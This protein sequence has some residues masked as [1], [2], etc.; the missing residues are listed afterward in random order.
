MKKLICLPAIFL[1]GCATIINSE[2]ASV[3]FTGPPEVTAKVQTPDGVF[4]VK[5]NSASLITR[6]R[7]DVPIEVTCN[8][9]TQ[10]GLIPTSFDWG[11]GGAGNLFFGGVPGWT[12]D[13]VGN[14]AYSPVS[15]YDVTSLCKQEREP[16]SQKAP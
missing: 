16:A 3:T 11:W 10:K 8:G 6:S 14:K 2:R 12:I 5:G 7:R 1:M 4:D 15:H 9:V 13:A